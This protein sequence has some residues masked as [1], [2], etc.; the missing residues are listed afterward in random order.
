MENITRDSYLVNVEKGDGILEF[1]E[2][3]LEIHKTIHN[4]TTKPEYYYD[5]MPYG[6]EYVDTVLMS[7]DDIENILGTEQ[8]RFVQQN[9]RKGLNTKY[10]QIKSSMLNNFDLREKPLQ[11]IVNDDGSLYVLFNGNTTHNILKKYTNVDNRLVAFYRKN[12]HFSEGKTLLIGG[13]QNSLE[14]PS[15][16]VTFE[17]IKQIIDGYLTTKELVLPQNPTKSDIN[18]FVTRIKKLITFSSSGTIS[19][20][21][22][23]V[24]KFVSDKVEEVTGVHSIKNVSTP[25]DVL[26]YLKSEKGFH[27][28][29]FHKY[30]AASAMAAKLFTTWK[31][32]KKDLEAS[33]VNGKSKVNPEN[34]TVDTVIHMGT[35]DPTNPVGDF[36]KKYNDF[37]NEFL[38]LE[39]FHLNSYADSAKKKNRYNIIG[40]FQ[41]VKELEDVFEF[42]SIVTP[43]EFV[44]E[45]DKR[46]K[47]T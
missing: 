4:P 36:F 2:D 23:V 1:T 44:K 8:S 11:V 29:N 27:D 35:P 15:G 30:H 6:I 13:N 40:F 22:T 47:I 43:E 32:K 38:E 10:N 5:L 37:W 17:D 46:Y 41:Q 14:N 3:H 42:G 24:N 18:K 31:N 34:I 9:Y 39:E 25:N 16:T 28:T 26:D 19:I 20:D 12:S 7:A 21:T 33:Y 45:Y